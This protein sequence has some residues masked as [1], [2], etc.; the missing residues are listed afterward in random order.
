MRGLLEYRSNVKK[1]MYW[2]CVQQYFGKYVCDKHIDVLTSL[3][4]FGLSGLYY[5]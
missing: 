5:I 2:I 3:G 1:F 4:Y